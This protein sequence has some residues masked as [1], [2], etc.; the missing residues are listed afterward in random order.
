MNTVDTS[1]INNLGLAVTPRVKNDELGQ[2]Q[3]LELMVAQLKNQDPLK[4]MESGEFLSQIAQFGTVTG[5]QDLHGSFAEL[6]GS[7]TSNQALQAAALIG[8]SVLVPSQQSLLPAGGSLTGTVELPT[9]TSDLTVGIYDGS[10]QLVRQLTLGQQ[11]AG[12][13]PFNWDGVTEAGAVAPPGLYQIKAEARSAGKAEAVPT[14]V[15]A[16]VDSVTLGAQ[17]EGITLNL[18]GL[19]VI[20]F[21]Q[22]RQIL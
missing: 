3:F 11:P 19:G 13:V 10:G 14:L 20:D 1:V 2:D 17:G 8:H 7:L 16:R 18:N 21:T 6:A 5:I 9:S 4:P 22:V 12:H 15:T